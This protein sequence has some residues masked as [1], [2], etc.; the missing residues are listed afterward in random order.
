MTSVRRTAAARRTG[1][2]T[3]TGA[4]PLPDDRR[5]VPPPHGRASADRPRRAV[6]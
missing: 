4:L 5:S 2:G 1:P 6:P 3:S